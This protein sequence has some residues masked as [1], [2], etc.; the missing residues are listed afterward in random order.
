MLQYETAVAM[1]RT[2][3]RVRTV[4]LIYIG[5]HQSVVLRLKTH[6]ANDCT[7]LLHKYVY[8]F[9]I[10]VLPCILLSIKLSFQQMHY[11]LKQNAT[12]CI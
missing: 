9:L 1:L 3:A 11:L 2:S 5:S 8:V 6:K 10:V 4:D 7:V 12:I